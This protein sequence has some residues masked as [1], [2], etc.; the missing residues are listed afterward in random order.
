[1]RSGMIDGVFCVLAN[2]FGSAANGFFMRQTSVLSSVA[3]SASSRSATVWPIASRFIQRRNEA[4]QSRASTGVPSWNSK[5]SR[6]RIVQRRPL[7]S[8]RWPSSI[9]GFGSSFSSRPNSVSNT[10]AAALRVT[11]AV[12][13]TA[14]SVT[15]LPCGT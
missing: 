2:A 5:P 7:S 3:S 4:T 13:N 6:S 11:C 12:V 9:C 15:R 8:T 10:I 14:S 1:M